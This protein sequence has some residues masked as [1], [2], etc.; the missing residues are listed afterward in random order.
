MSR[1]QFPGPWCSC[2]PTKKDMGKIMSKAQSSLIGKTETVGAI[3]EV[4][5]T[6]TVYV[7]D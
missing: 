7:C 3:E 2:S 4:T 1:S 5:L 6:V